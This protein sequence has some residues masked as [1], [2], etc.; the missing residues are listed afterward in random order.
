MGAWVGGW[1]GGIET[2]AIVVPTPTELQSLPWPSKAHRGCLFCSRDPAGIS[3]GNLGFE[4]PQ[5]WNRAHKQSQKRTPTKYPVLGNPAILTG[6]SR[7]NSRKASE[8]LPR[9]HNQEPKPSNT[10]PRLDPRFSK[11]SLPHYAGKPSNF[12]GMA[13]AWGLSAL[14]SY[15]GAFLRCYN[16]LVAPTGWDIAV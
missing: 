6:L 12:G 5:P 3:H 11:P 14:P 2:E 15:Q 16:I 13:F 1:V 9:S 7:A 4:G 10:K 8:I